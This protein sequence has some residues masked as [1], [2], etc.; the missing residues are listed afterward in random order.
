MSLRPEAAGSVPA[1]TVRVARAAFPKGSPYL[2]LRDALGTVYADADF[3]ALFP[4]RGRSAAAPWRLALVTVFQFAEGLS[5]RQAAEAV[6]GRV[7]W[8]YALGLALEDPGFDHSVLCEFRAR[9]VAG[10]AEATLLDGLLARCRAAGLVRARGR[11]RTDSTHVLAAVRALNRLELA[12]ETLRA[13]LAALAAA[14]PAWLQAGA[15]PAWAERYGPRFGGGRWAGRPQAAAAQ[16]A[17]LG[18]IGAD[19]FRLLAAAYDPAAPAW[20]REVPAVEALRRVWVQRFHAPAAGGGPARPREGDDLPPSALRIDSPYD[21]EARC[22]AK[23]ELTWVGYKVHLTEACD[24]DL[25]HLITHVETAVATAPDVAA[26]DRVHRGLA[27]K[28]LLPAQHAVDGGYVDAALLAASPAAHG[29]DLLGPAPPDTSWQAQAGRG[30]AAAAFVVDWAGR[31]VTCPLGR[32]SAV[33]SASRDAGGTAV[34]HV[35]FAPEDCRACPSRARCTRAARG[36]R[37]LK[38]RAQA[39]HEA[40]QAAR[41]RQATPAF[42]AAYAARAGVEGTLSQGTRALGLR[43]ARYRGLAKTHLQHTA[44]AAALSLARLDAWWTATPRAPTRRSPFVR[45]VA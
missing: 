31:T 2:R 30:F 26:T 12:G 7:D 4:A 11:Q 33:W 29:V 43:R 40:L 20:L 45:L 44:T 25:P 37:A 36:P 5:D 22:G 32:P 21:T 18:E 9:L 41:A 42:R 23:R 24:P 8:K 15:P 13:A 35:R 27:A 38:L 17:L 14:A 34:I 19:G 6:R 39:E 1:E 10:G 28:A 16:A 3:A